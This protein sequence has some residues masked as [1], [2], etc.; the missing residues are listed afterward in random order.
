MTLTLSILLLETVSPCH[1]TPCNT[2]PA[3]ICLGPIPPPGSPFRLALKQLQTVSF[4]YE[5]HN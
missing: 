1:M 3:L 5:T 4:G 2:L